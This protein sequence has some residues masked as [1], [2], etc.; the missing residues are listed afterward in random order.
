MTYSTLRYEVDA[1]G[2]LLLILARPDKLNAFTVEMC[3][4]LVDAYGRASQDDAVKA[5]VVTGEGRAFCA[6]MDLSV[7]GNVFGLDEQLAPTLQD[8]RERSHLPE[9][10]R[11]VRDTG[12]RVVLAMLDCLKPIIGAINGPAV[13]VGS[14]MLLPMDFRFASA[15][16]RFGFVFG[17]IGVTPEGCSTWFLPR[18]VGLETA[19]EWM[20]KAEIFDAEEALDKGL[21]RALLSA[22]SLVAEARAFAL[23]LVRDRSPV[24]VALIRQM[25]F[26]NANQTHPLA[27]HEI[28]SL[29][30][31]YTSQADGKEGVCAFLEKR[32]PQF[33]GK[34]SNLPSFYPW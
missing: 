30:M 1:D 9:I 33:C 6:G 20:Y 28:E 2:I 16:A 15:Q 13:G 18:I 11:G 27:A 12:G 17:K 23:S 24:S 5:I 10:E 32:K 26:R 29:A 14:T 21:V 3:D 8:M 7:P 19:L 34:A 25:L 4:E 31:F 22:Q